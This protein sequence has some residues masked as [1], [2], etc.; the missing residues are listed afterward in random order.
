L[1]DDENTYTFLPDMF[2]DIRNQRFAPAINTLAS[3]G[4]VNTNTPKFYPDNYIRHYDFVIFL[5]N[6]LLIAQNQSLS[7]FSAVSQFADV[8]NNASYLAQLDYAFDHGL[9]DRLTTSK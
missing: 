3:L 1:P 4:I 5:I 9:I 6:S 2:T 8:D 7:N